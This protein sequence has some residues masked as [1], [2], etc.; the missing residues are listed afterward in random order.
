MI[1]EGKTTTKVLIDYPAY[2]LDPPDPLHKLLMP[3]RKWSQS[4]LN[5]IHTPTYLSASWDETQLL[6]HST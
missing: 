5:T 4:G 1:V 2:P 3:A 6:L